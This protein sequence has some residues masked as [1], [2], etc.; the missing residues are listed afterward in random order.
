MIC[1]EFHFGCSQPN[2]IILALCSFI[3]HFDITQFSLNSFANYL[4]LPFC[5]ISTL[6]GKS[7]Y[8]S[9]AVVKQLLETQDRSYRTTLQ[10]FVEDMKQEL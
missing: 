10:I 9:L 1:H 6:E 8:L 4:Q 3:S 2:F 5:R 7:D